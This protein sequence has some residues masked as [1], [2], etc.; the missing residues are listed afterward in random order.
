VAAVE[1]APAGADDLV[2]GA[3]LIRWLA[4]AMLAVVI[5]G[6]LFPEQLNG[7]LVCTLNLGLG[8]L[9]LGLACRKQPPPAGSTEPIERQVLAVLPPQSP[10]PL[11]PD[12]DHGAELRRLAQALLDGIQHCR[13]DMDRVTALAR[14]SS[15]QVG[16]AGE[17]ARDVSRCF[18]ALRANLLSSAR[19][20][21]ELQ[22][23]A[24]QI[25]GIVEV[26]KEVARM[27][28]LLA[29]NAAIEAS[30]VGQAGKGFAVVAAEVKNLARRTD[31]AARSAGLL[32]E[33]LAQCCT[34]ADLE[35]GRT[36]GLS[37]EGVRFNDTALSSLQ[38]VE[39]GAATRIQ[40]VGDFL[41]R[42]DEQLVGT[43]TLH[44]A[45]ASRA[46]GT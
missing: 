7:R 43:Q 1:H 22:S 40:V 5:G 45:I 38:A 9:L 8:L 35:L 14:A 28:N 10:Q 33:E 44:G 11:S 27:T 6:L 34:A 46:A 30:R 23:K 17:A 2:P 37:D 20:A 29:I 21:H 39:Q 42:L 3:G 16:A 24:R 26:I 19:M 32:T 25:G 31:E 13:Q 4:I 41:A 18:E 12:R 15:A 36:V